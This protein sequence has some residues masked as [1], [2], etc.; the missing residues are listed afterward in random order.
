MYIR[1]WINKSVIFLMKE[2]LLDRKN[3]N[4]STYSPLGFILFASY[5]SNF[6]PF[7]NIK[8]RRGAQYRSLLETNVSPLNQF[9]NIGNKKYSLT[10]SLTCI[11]RE[12]GNNLQPNSLNFAWETMHVCTLTWSSWKSTYFL[13]KCHLIFFK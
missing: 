4:I 8:I 7:P 3:L 12:W 13:A 1:G 5:F 11:I 10:H 6:W 2:N 9:S